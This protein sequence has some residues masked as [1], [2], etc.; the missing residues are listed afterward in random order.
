MTQ[1]IISVAP[2]GARKT[3]KDHPAIP[4]NPAELAQEAKACAEA[5]AALFH[6]HIR[7]Q[8][9]RHS[10]D[11]DRYRAAIDAIKTA[12]GENIIIQATTESCGIYTPEQQIDM[13]KNL[14]PE[15]ISVAIR[16]LI[17]SPDHIEQ[18]KDFLAWVHAQKIMPQYI[19]YSPEE[20][21]YFSELRA[22]GVIPA[23]NKYFL[24]VLGKKNAPDV[25]SSYATPA[26]V[27]K[28]VQSKNQYLQPDDVWGICAFGAHENACM[29]EALKHG[30]HARIGFENNHVLEDGSVAANNAALVV[31]LQDSVK[32]TALSRKAT[33]AS[34]ARKLLRGCL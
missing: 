5:G 27:A 10:L 33:P 12:V 15:A 13:V 18:G 9:D 19:L 17:P 31:Q 11:V 26:D 3:K 28:F 14:Q 24:F 29:L 32:A 22:Q 20:I 30:G 6:L 2:N 21:K 25:A 7:D 8:E 23:G 34:E 1:L 16:E 4:L